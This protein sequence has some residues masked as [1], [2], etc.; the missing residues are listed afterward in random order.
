MSQVETQLRCRAHRKISQAQIESRFWFDSN[1]WV[2]MRE[3]TQI[4]EK[5]N[6]KNFLFLYLIWKRDIIDIDENC[7]QFALILLSRLTLFTFTNSAGQLLRSDSQSYRKVR[8]VKSNLIFRIFR[9]CLRELLISPVKL[10][11][12][13]FS[14]FSLLRALMLKR[15]A[16]GKLSCILKLYCMPSSVCLP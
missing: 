3:K 6:L 15:K 5:Y 11:R 2:R 14:N 9:N 10:V 13:L 1:H 12:Y 16:L 4:L 8:N 7:F